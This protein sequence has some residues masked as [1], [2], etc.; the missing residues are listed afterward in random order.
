M[1]LIISIYYRNLYRCCNSSSIT[2]VN[3]WGIMNVIAVATSWWLKE[4]P[5]IEFRKKWASWSRHWGSVSRLSRAQ[6]RPRQRRTLKRSGAGDFL[7]LWRIKTLCIIIHKP[8]TTIMPKLYSIRPQDWGLPCTD[9]KDTWEAGATSTI[10][11]EPTDDEGWASWRRPEHK[12]CAME[13][14]NDWWG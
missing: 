13:W 9:S 10:D 4:H 5:H 8:N 7:Q 1:W 12:Y 11:P 6:T 3:R 14:S 2:S